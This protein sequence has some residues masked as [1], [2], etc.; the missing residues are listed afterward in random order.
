MNSLIEFSPFALLL[1]IYL[2]V[3][4]LHAVYIKVSGRILRGVVSWKHSFI[5]ALAM[6]VLTLI[7]RMA[8]SA[9]GKSV[10]LTVVLPFGFVLSLVLGGWFFGSRGASLQG[11]PLGLLGGLQLSALA[12]VLLTELAF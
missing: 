4:A 9:G 12:Y 8:A 3:G 11:Q 7:G 10:P 5:F 6:T 1:S 2:A